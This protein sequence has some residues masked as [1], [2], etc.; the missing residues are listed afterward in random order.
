MPRNMTKNRN[1]A[2]ARRAVPLMPY[3]GIRPMQIF[4]ML[5]LFLA[6]Q[7]GTLLAVE[8]TARLAFEKTA[9][10]KGQTL[11]YRIKKGDTIAG[12]VRKLGRSAPGYEAIKRLNPHIPDLHRIYPGQKLILARKG[13]QNSK[14]EEL[15]AFRN[16]TA[17]KGDS[18]TRIILDELHAKPAEVV[19]VLRSVKLLNPEVGNYNKIYPGQILRIPDVKTTDDVQESPASGTAAPAAGEMAKA[20]PTAVL[21]SEKIG[22]LR[23]IIRQLNGAVITSGNYYIPLPDLGQV[24]VDCATIPVVELE[25]GT[26]VLLDLTGRLPDD[27]AKIVQA[28]WRNY[29][30]LKAGGGDD[31]ASFLQKII[32]KS[33]SY[34]MVKVDKPVFLE[35]EPQVKLSL[36]WLITKKTAAGSA[37][38]Q[39]GLIFTADKSQL[40]PAPAILLAKKKGLNICE[41]LTGRVQE[42]R[43]GGGVYAP[44]PQIKGDANDELLHNFLTFLGLE[45]LKNREVKIF[46]AQKDGFDLSIKPEWLVKKG[47]KTLLI[48]KSKLPQQFSDILK[49]EGMEPF[50]LAG[51]GSRKSLLEGVLSA[52]DIPC[53]FAFFSI[54]EPGEKSRVAVSFSAL[55]VETGQGEFYLVDFEIGRE[56]YALLADNWK[57]NVIRY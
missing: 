19:K 30:F 34:H 38:S 39:L 26:T 20:T 29:H 40:L 16:Y 27:L 6:L 5:I 1:R 8:G 25:D 42:G 48:H 49:A 2:G 45:P 28:N 56:A 11:T 55:K 54:P 10:I 46:D 21:S 41:I 24:T 4:I 36:D 50:Y 43:P 37:P 47:G 44:V 12:I 31:I 32:L 53:R 35:D 18:I 17:Q 9:I 22:L 3:K 15:Q 23:Q 51:G 14:R 52:L 57:L 33:G 7:S 13:E